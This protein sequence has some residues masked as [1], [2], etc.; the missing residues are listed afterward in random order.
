MPQGSTRKTDLVRLLNCMGEDTDILK[1]TTATVDDRK[2]YQKV[3]NKLE[4][5]SRSGET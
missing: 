3:M 5:F 2:E 1:S 4:E